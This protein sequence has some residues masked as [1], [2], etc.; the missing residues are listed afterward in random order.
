M[1]W[2]QAVEYCVT[3]TTAGFDD[4]RLPNNA[5]LESLVDY[6]IPYIG[7]TSGINAIFT[8][9]P[10]NYFYSSTPMIGSAT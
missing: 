10:T 3:E 9:M 5:E 2:A 8:R 6:T 7:P 4:W 1:T